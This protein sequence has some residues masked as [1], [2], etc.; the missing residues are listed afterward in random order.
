MRLLNSFALVLFIIFTVVS[1]TKEKVDCIPL[2]KASCACTKEYTPVCGCDGNTYSNACHAECWGISSFSPGPCVENTGDEPFGNW[3]FAGYLFADQLNP[4]KLVKAH[5]Y[6]VWLQLAEEIKQGST[7]LFFR[8]NSSVNSYGGDFNF[9]PSGELSFTN[10]YQTE[11][12][13]PP[14]AMSFE[15]SYFKALASSNH[16]QITK[17]VLYLT[18]FVDGKSERMVFVPGF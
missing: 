18:T 16:F 6:D 5:E 4:D 3:Y 7:H 9:K 13:G 12:A 11:K 8:G 10:M 2:D 14:A 1:C 17:N 15:E